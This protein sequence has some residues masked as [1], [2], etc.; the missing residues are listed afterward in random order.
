MEITKYSD[1]ESADKAIENNEP[2]MA[3][4]SFDGS[5]AYVCHIDDHSFQSFIIKEEHR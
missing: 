5:K 3:V 4:I 2:L 1:Y